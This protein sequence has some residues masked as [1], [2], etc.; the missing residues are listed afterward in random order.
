MA[1]RGGINRAFSWLKKILEVTEVTNVP[2]IVLP[3]VRAVADLFGWERMP[4][5]TVVNNVGAAATNQVV[6]AVVPGDIVRLILEAQVVSSDAAIAQTLWINH[7]GL[8]GAGLDIGVAQPINQAI[9]FNGTPAVM[10]RIIFL[11]P[12]ERIVG[13]STPAPGVGEELTLT[14]RHIDLPI[15]EY[16]PYLS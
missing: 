15:G 12:G 4:E 8:V 3:D 2:D 10:D 16:I 14:F 9:G 11:Q 13:R 6:S 5:G 7:R 1:R